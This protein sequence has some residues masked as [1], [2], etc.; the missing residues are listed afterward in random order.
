[1]LKKF[2]IRTV[3]EGHNNIDC[4]STSKA[5]CGADLEAKTLPPDWVWDTV[6]FEVGELSNKEKLTRL[7]EGQHHRLQIS[8]V[9]YGR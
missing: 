4:I 2:I 5:S 9:S 3:W 1:M 6:A 7:M 8:K